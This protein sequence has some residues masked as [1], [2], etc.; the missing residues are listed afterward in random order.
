MRAFG[1]FI[2]NAGSDLCRVITSM[3]AS[4]FLIQGLLGKGSSGK[5]YRVKR[6]TDGKAYAIKIIKVRNGHCGAAAG[7][8]GA[9]GA[10]LAALFRGR[11]TVS[12]AWRVV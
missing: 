12:A 2:G 3:P 4:D 6:I 5:V 11:A 8:G 10:W 1:Q 9:P 7:K